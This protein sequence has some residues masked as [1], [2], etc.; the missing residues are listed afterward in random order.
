M[1]RVVFIILCVLFADAVYAQSHEEKMRRIRNGVEAAVAKAEAKAKKEREAKER[2]EREERIKTERRHEQ[3]RRQHEANFNRQMENLNLV[4]AEDFLNSPQ[5][6]EGGFSTKVKKFMENQQTP[7]VVATPKKENTK[8]ANGDPFAN[9]GRI[10][11]A[12]WSGNNYRGNLYDNKRAGFGNTQQRQQAR[13]PANQIRGQYKPNQNMRQGV[14]NLQRTN[15]VPKA[16]MQRTQPQIVGQASQRQRSIQTTK[17]VQA[18]Q[19]KQPPIR[20]ELVW[21]DHNG[22]LRRENGNI[23]NGPSKSPVVLYIQQSSSS[24]DL[25]KV[26]TKRIDYATKANNITIYNMPNEA[27]RP[28]KAPTSPDIKNEAPYLS[29]RDNKKLSKSINGTDTKTAFELQQMH[30]KDMMSGM[31]SF[32]NRQKWQRTYDYEPIGSV[33]TPARQVTKKR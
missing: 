24:P 16:K 30:K 10:G 20:E 7:T 27:P 11:S 15:A 33:K 4:S 18:Q 13:V 1:K 28:P 14:V 32:D 5:Q 23:Q 22:N 17:K 9:S 6:H 19:K 31:S 25:A 2:K 12:S 21:V 8:R 26:D 29:D 3:Q